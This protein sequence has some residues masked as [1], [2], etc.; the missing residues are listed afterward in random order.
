M[1]GSGL[2]RAVVGAWRRWAERRART[3]GRQV[4]H[5]ARSRRTGAAYRAWFA[6]R[7]RLARIAAPAASFAWSIDADAHFVAAGIDDPEPHLLLVPL[8][9]EQV[10][11]FRRRFSPT[12]DRVDLVRATR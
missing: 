3:A 12:R 2:M 1:G 6:D 4:L 8:T 9:P 7:D 11:E 5:A 10:A